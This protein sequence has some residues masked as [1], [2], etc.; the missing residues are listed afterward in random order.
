[1]RSANRFL[2]SLALLLISAASAKA[3]EYNPV[4]NIGDKAPIWTELAGVDGEKHSVSD[5]P[6]DHIIVVAFTCNTCPYATDYESRLNAMVEEAKGNK[7]T[8]IAIN[9]NSARGDDLDSMRE[10]SESEKL[11]FPYLK[12]EDGSVAKAFGAS[13]TPEF[14]VLNKDREVIYMGAMDD[15][16]DEAKVSKRYVQDAIT[17]AQEG[18]QPEVTE[19]I[20][21]GCNIRFPRKRRSREGE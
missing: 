13:R 10:R 3:G 4:L 18:K 8:V 14:F 7:L 11:R 20:A 19:A 9:S 2:A 16:T 15:S 1:M 12:D 21:I 5:I 17:A 6:R